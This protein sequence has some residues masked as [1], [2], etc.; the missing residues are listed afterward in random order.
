MAYIQVGIVAARNPK[1]D[2]MPAISIYREADKD[3]IV[4]T[5]DNAACVFAK[6]LKRYIEDCKAHG[7]DV[8]SACR[9]LPEKRCV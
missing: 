4:K 7:I 6:D 1:G 8:K 5:M 3:V 9:G 2:F